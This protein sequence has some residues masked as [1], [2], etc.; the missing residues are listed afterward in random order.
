MWSLARQTHGRG[1]RLGRRSSA[2]EE[3]L[4]AAQSSR[5]GKWD[6]GGLGGRDDPQVDVGGEVAEG[7]GVESGAGPQLRE[8]VL[9]DGQLAFEAA[10]AVW[11][12]CRC[13]NVGSSSGWHGPGGK[14][15]AVGRSAKSPL[16]G[17]SPRGRRE[18]GEAVG[19]RRGLLGEEGPYQQTGEAPWGWCEPGRIAGLVRVG[20][21]VEGSSAH[22]NITEGGDLLEE[23]VGGGGRH[24]IETIQAPER[25]AWGEGDVG[26]WRQ[27]SV[28][29]NLLSAE[30][31]GGVDVGVLGGRCDGSTRPSA[32]RRGRGLGS[33]AGVRIATLGGLLEGSPGAR[34]EA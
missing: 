23:M 21:R 27:R 6:G 17:Q 28:K 19:G 8:L 1:E 12:R 20:R 10:K 31:K 7:G 29:R 26:R 30:D 9:G 16:G 11:G 34:W 18:S 33:G 4:S 15:Q 32:R 14:P 24:P 25:V 13:R 3:R 2:V 22:L 5:E